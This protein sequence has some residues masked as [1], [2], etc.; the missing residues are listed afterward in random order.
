MCSAFDVVVRQRRRRR[1]G[2]ACC[3]DVTIGITVVRGWVLVWVCVCV[4]YGSSVSGMW[5]PTELAPQV[6]FADHGSC[7]ATINQ[8]H[9]A[10]A[11]EPTQRCESPEDAPHAHTHTP[12]HTH[13]TQLCATVSR[14]SNRI[15]RCLALRTRVLLNLWSCADVLCVG[16]VGGLLS[17]FGT[18]AKAMSRHKDLNRAMR[19]Q[20]GS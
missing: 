9:P 18:L 14:V 16:R 5:Q 20:G 1:R 10:P 6:G 15:N 2:H 17:L 13:T 4:G 19:A 8:M 12:A 3:N 11:S 7:P